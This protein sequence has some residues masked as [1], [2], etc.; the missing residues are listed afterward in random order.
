MVGSLDGAIVV[1]KQ[2]IKGRLRKGVIIDVID[3]KHMNE[4]ISEDFIMPFLNMLTSGIP[5][6]FR[7]KI[8]RNV[9]NETDTK[10]Q[11]KRLVDELKELAG[12]GLV[13]PDMEEILNVY[14][15]RATLLWEYK[16][17]KRSKLDLKNLWVKSGPKVCPNCTLL[18]R[19]ALIMWTT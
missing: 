5:E 19:S 14:V 4:K 13:A 2:A 17:K 11:I 7:D 10:A 8:T 12:R 9:F 15:K 3:D 6:V 16:D 18:R 1:A